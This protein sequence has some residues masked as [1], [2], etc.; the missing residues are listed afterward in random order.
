ML[1]IRL[2]T[3][4]T[5]KLLS[6]S[7]SQVPYRTLL[8]Q[9]TGSIVS[10][11][12]HSCGFNVFKFCSFTDGVFATLKL[13]LKRNSFIF[14]DTRALQQL[15][16]SP[17]TK[18]LVICI[19]EVLKVRS[20]AQSN[21]L[22]SASVQ[23]DVLSKTERT[24]KRSN[25]IL[26]IGTSPTFALRTSELVQSFNLWPIVSIICPLGLVNGEACKLQFTRAKHHCCIVRSCFGGLALAAAIV[27][28]TSV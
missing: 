23:A 6:S 26:V 18:H 5:V 11:L 2:R 15:L 9:S 14:S 28:A 7:A 25:Y 4:L 21:G 12:Y 8:S 10:R 3:N 17:L 19:S 1:P 27:N 16:S 22:T 24:L 20:I 13:S